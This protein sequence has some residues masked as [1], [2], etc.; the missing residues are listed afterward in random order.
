MTNNK[1]YLPSLQLA[2]YV[3]SYLII[4]DSTS[5]LQENLSVSVYP[6]GLNALG[7]SFGDSTLHTNYQG[8]ANKL[9]RGSFI[10]GTQEQVY[11][12]QPTFNQKE[13]VIIFKPGVLGKLLRISMLEVK[14]CITEVDNIIK[15]EERIC[16]LLS[17][18]ENHFQQIAIIESWLPKQLEDIDITPDLTQLIIADIV[19]NS[20]DIKVYDICN[21]YKINKKYIE[22]KFAECMGI[23]PKKYAEIIRFNTVLEILSSAD[24]ASWLAVKSEAGFMDYSHLSKHIHKLTGLPPKKLKEKLD[25]FNDYRFVADFNNLFNSALLLKD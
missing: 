6:N 13:F 17:L 22:R 21:K 2:N 15:D 9:N 20:G 18:A 3:S 8:K 23:S 7:F 12:M 16:E 10:V 5:I 1:F 4:E 11:K 25:H 24:D 19:Q 14:N